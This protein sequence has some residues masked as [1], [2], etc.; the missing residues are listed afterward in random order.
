MFLSC[1]RMLVLMLA[2]DLSLLQQPTYAEK[3]FVD[4]LKIHKVDHCKG[5]TFSKQAKDAHGNVMQII[6][7]MFSD[8]CLHCIALLSRRKPVSGIK[9]TIT[10]GFGAQGQ[11]YLIDFQSMPDGD[12]QLLLNSMIMGSRS[13]RPF[14]LLQSR[15]QVLLQRF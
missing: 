2:F 9:N 5:T 10:F 14:H 3:L 8:C 11:V 6:C 7:K 1:T 13:L 15:Q 12:F 4:L